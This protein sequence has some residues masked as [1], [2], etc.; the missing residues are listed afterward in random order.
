[1]SILNNIKFLD[2]IQL[3]NVHAQKIILTDTELETQDYRY[4]YQGI[5]NTAEEVFPSGTVSNIQFSINL[6][7]NKTLLIYNKDS[8][9]KFQIV[10]NINTIISYG[11]IYTTTSSIDNIVDVK[12]IDSTHVAI[13]YNS[14]TTSNIFV[15]NINEYVINFG[16]S[17]IVNTNTITEEASLSNIYDSKFLL[18]F[19]DNV[20][21]TNYLELLEYSDNNITTITDSLLEISTTNIES[22]QT[23]ILDST[24]AIIIYYVASNTSYYSTIVNIN[25]LVI[26][27]N[28]PAFI[29]SSD[30]TGQISSY[31]YNN[32]E[33]IVFYTETSSLII[34][35]II[36]SGN[37]IILKEANLVEN[38]ACSFINITLIDTNIFV[39][40]YSKSGKSYTY[41][42]KLI[43]DIVVLDNKY[44]SYAIDYAGKP[45]IVQLNNTYSMISFVPD[46]SP[47]NIFLQIISNITISSNKKSNKQV[48]ND[49]TIFLS[50]FED[51]LESGNVLSDISGWRIKRKA[52]DT[53]LYTTLDNVLPT[54]NTY[55]DNSPRNNIEYTYSL[56][57]YD[58]NGNESLGI[59]TISTVSFDSWILSDENDFYLFYA[60]WDGIQT[61]DIETNKDTYV[62]ENYTKYPVISFSNQNFKKSTLITIP[63]QYNSTSLTYDLDVFILN[64]LETFINNGNYKHLRNPSGEIIK[65]ICSKFKYKYNDK[66]KEQPY[67]IEFEWTEVGEGIL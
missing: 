31:L 35:K 24:K 62:Y 66:I 52:S 65:I 17:S 18:F 29:L 16:V 59:T 48:W 25:N 41:I 11:T 53:T 54:I 39:L 33:L 6:E 10:T 36:I 37:N 61:S 13:L 7:D 67:T 26:T 19:T 32:Y 43:E 23:Y 50:D 57:S 28:N 34:Q 12:K 21:N 51:T 14:P 2:N 47:N 8:R 30:G 55:V 38:V 4:I 3:D 49:N 20:T 46:T 40:T 64:E 42:C 60:G 5:I 56:F 22:L 44:E 1:M 58:S 9:F 45:S 27:N 63:F 15:I